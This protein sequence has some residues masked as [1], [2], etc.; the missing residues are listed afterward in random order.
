MLLFAAVLFLIAATFG[1]AILTAVLQEKQTNKT[2]LYLH[3][4]IA[5][6]AILLMIIYLIVF[7]G[8]SLL[9]ISLTLF[10][11]A[12]L[13]G[14]TLFTLDMKKK[15]VPKWLAVLHPLVAIAGLI[16]LVIYILP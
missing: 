16:T 5:S 15:P 9:I 2:V 10:I 11:L 3:G 4:S 13:G 7:G 14:L 6:I 1:L 12:A 8:D